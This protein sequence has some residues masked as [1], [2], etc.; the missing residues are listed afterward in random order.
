MPDEK[1]TIRWD[2]NPLQQQQQ[3]PEGKKDS[4]LFRP[5]RGAVILSTNGSP[6]GAENARFSCILGT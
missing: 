6:D 2:S 4:L 3:H 1:P 5:H